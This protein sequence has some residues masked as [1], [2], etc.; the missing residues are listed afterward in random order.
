VCFLHVSQLFGSRVAYVKKKADPVAAVDDA[1]VCFVAAAC[2]AAAA[3]TT[4]TLC[5]I[6]ATVAF[7]VE[8]WRGEMPRPAEVALTPAWHVWHDFG[9]GV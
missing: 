9:A 4:T 1:E 5:K 7:L 8:N 3:R 6:A 2:A